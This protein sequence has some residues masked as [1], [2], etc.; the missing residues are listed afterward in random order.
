MLGAL[1]EAIDQTALEANLRILLLAQRGVDADVGDPVAPETDLDAMCD[2]LHLSARAR[3]AV[4]ETLGAG[5]ERHAPWLRALLYM[6][7]GQPAVDA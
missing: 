5:L 1:C 2:V 3:R 6:A 7:G 4:R